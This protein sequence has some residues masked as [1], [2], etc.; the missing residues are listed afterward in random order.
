MSN[1]GWNISNKN[2]IK[3]KSNLKIRFMKWILLILDEIRKEKVS[4]KRKDVQK[5]YTSFV[6]LI[7]KEDTE[8]AVSYFNHIARVRQ[9]YILDMSHCFLK[10]TVLFQ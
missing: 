1:I 3:K 5:D 4:K 6:H 9:K 7:W 8:E 2:V 10:T